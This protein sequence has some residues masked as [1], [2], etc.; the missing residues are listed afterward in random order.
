MNQPEIRALPECSICN[1]EPAWNKDPEFSIHNFEPAWN[2]GPYRFSEKK[3]LNLL[4]IAHRPRQQKP[5][6]FRLAFC[7]PHPSLTPLS[8]PNPQQQIY[9]SFWKVCVGWHRK[10]CNKHKGVCEVSVTWAGVSHLN[11]LERSASNRI[12]S[13]GKGFSSGKDLVRINVHPPFCFSVSLHAHRLGL[14]KGMW[15][16]TCC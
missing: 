8:C 1:Y 5:K 16:W 2:K 6:N 11:T 4:L 12:L 9:D 7:L 14:L 10:T 3:I 13:V 15:D